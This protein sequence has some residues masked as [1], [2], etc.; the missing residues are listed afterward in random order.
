MG[1]TC[2]LLMFYP[3][4]NRM[5]MRVSC[6]HRKESHKLQLFVKVVIKLAIKLLS[7]SMRSF[8]VLLKQARLP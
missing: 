7:V 2:A 4:N 1:L 5:Q 6:K 8:A 3:K